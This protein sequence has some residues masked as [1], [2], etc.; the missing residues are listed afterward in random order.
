MKKT[1]LNLEPSGRSYTGLITSS[2]NRTKLYL[3]VALVVMGGVL[4]LAWS[5]VWARGA[6]IAA[7]EKKL[8][9]AEGEARV[10][11][12]DLDDVRNSPL[13]YLLLYKRA[14]LAR[15]ERIEPRWDD[16][17]SETWAAAKKN[18]V[19]PEVALAIIEHESFFNPEAIGSRGEFG[20]MQ[21]YPPA[22]PQFDTSRGFEIPYNVGF[23]CRIFAGC[24]KE[25]K[26]NLREAL[27]LYNGR[28]ELP[29][30][31]IPYPDRVLSGRTMRRKK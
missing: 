9:A 23:G 4:G 22:W 30:G 25:A 5:E 16:I 10:L 2:L 17:V 19:P 12:G 29:E 21:I 28:G 3:I 7:L 1:E 26:G 11:A 6:R 24:L 27:R 8:E 13:N 31:M 20:L 18:G 15:L 14:S